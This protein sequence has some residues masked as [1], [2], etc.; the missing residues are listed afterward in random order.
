MDTT[1]PAVSP[2]RQRMTENMRIRKLEPRPQEAYTRAVRKLAISLKRAPDTATVEDPH[3][4]PAA[5]GGH[6]H[7]SHHAQRVADRAEG[8][9]RLHLGR[10]ELMARMQPVKLPRTLP[11]ALSMQEAASLIAAGAPGIVVL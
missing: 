6:R 5:P 4:F 11:V 7:L 8:L 3:N 9:L 1:T 10:G 2:L